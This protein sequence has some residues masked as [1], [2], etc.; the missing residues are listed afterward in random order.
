M[1]R[2]KEMNFI[3]VIALRHE[4]E[5]QIKRLQRQASRPD[6]FK[7]QRKEIENYLE[8]RRR[9]ISVKLLLSKS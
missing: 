6:S 8:W 2:M 1:Q 5:R 4:V 3:I 9:S 7:K